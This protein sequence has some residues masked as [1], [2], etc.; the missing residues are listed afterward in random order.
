[1]KKNSHILRRGMRLPGAHTVRHADA[2]PNPPNPA[3]PVAPA[4]AAQPIGLTA[5][6]VT[7]MLAT[8][9]AQLLE[10]FKALIPAPTSS[11]PAA[12][13]TPAAPAPGTPVSP[14]VN[15]QLQRLTK[16]KEELGKRLTAM[17]TENQKAKAAVLKANKDSHLATLVAGFDFFNEGARSSALRDLDSAIT[18]N[19]DGSFVSV[20][21]TTA[22]AYVTDYV[23]NNAYLLKAQRAAGSG[24]SGAAGH[25]VNGGKPVTL[26]MIRPGMEPKDLD[27]V[28]GQIRQVMPRPDGP[29]R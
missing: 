7:Q 19:E 24:N 5:D 3:A 17:E 15:T 29:P 27:A 13:A 14:E 4:A 12:P 26:E 22:E 18:M 21:N 1:M 8:N 9:N 2:D 10:A 28:W 16:D 25:L 11:A 23:T 6:A 20:A